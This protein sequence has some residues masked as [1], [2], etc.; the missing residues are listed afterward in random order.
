MGRFTRDTPGSKSLERGLLLLRTFRPGVS[1]LTN[2]ELAKRTGLPRPTVSRLTHSLVDAGFLSYDLERRAYRLAAVFL[3]LAQAFRREV[4]V[5][6]V[7]LPLMRK[8]AE[9]EHI[10]VGLAVPDQL[11]MVYLESVRE[12]R[13][14]IFRRISAGSRIPMELT[15]L[16][17]AYLAGLA[18]VERQVLLKRI[19]A[20]Y[21]QGW[22]PVRREINRAMVDIARLG[23]CV[24]VW[25]AGMMALASFLKGP[26]QAVYAV[27]ISFPTDDSDS[28]ALIK[29]YSHM[30]RGLVDDIEKRWIA[31]RVES[32][33]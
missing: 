2:S 21:G 9:G 8:V 19:E 10:N 3:T 17:R 4:S 11:E 7:A 27:N 25:Q 24:A 33:A 15:S 18:E 20:Q 16:G 32:L 26:D 30:L 29:R 23:Y 13:R 12:S 1:I 6:S 31:T 28:A 5:L 14:G 22:A